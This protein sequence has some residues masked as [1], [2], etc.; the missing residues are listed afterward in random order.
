MIRLIMSV[1][2]AAT[3]VAGNTLA[4]TGLDPNGQC[5]GDA[6]GDAEVRINELI[7]AVNNSLN[8]CPRRAIEIAFAAAV[9]DEDFTCGGVYEGVGAA[10]S[11]LRLTDFRFYVSNVRLLTSG[12]DEVP[13]QL[14]EDGIWQRDGVAL[15]DF[16]DGSNGCAFGN[17]PINT[18]VRGTA[19]AGVYTGVR[20]DMGVPFEL[21]H[22]NA[23]LETEPLNVT[24]MFWNWNG[25]YKFIR[26]DGFAGP[27]DDA[28]NYNLHLGSTGCDSAA[29]VVPPSQPCANPNL[30]EITL[31]GFNPA[32]NVIVADLAPVLADA[33]LETNQTETAP[34]CQSQPFDADCAPVFPKL[35]LAFGETPAEPQK[36]FRV[37]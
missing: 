7:T 34:G 20:F 13:L 21:N 23:E 25:G 29:P 32:T 37:E 24:A 31:N 12:G 9:G 6:N 30:P 8:G 4:Q 11:T 35:G 15:L 16:E 5:I 36:L 10:A 3:L 33:D 19:P 1:A 14:D 17:A 2:T 28:V 26:V 27:I 22:G 18:A